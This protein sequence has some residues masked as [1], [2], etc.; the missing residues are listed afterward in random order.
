MEIPKNYNPT[1]AEERW[2]QHWLEKNI[3]IVL[4]TIESH[5]Q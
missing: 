4:L 3:S 2:Y 1:E 5:L